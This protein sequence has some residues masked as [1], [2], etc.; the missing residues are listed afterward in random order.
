MPMSQT[1]IREQCDTDLP[2]YLVQIIVS[3]TVT[4][5]NLNVN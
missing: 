4:E 2:I 5:H 3:L 1:S